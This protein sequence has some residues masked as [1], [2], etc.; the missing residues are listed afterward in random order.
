[1]LSAKALMKSAWS[2]TS[3]MIL[4]GNVASCRIG[5]ICCPNFIHVKY[6]CNPT[7]KYLQQSKMDEQI[8]AFK[9][10]NRHRNTSKHHISIS[11][12][13]T[14]VQQYLAQYITHK[15]QQTFSVTINLL[16][17]TLHIILKNIDVNKTSFNITKPLQTH[18]HV[19][20]NACIRWSNCCKH[21]C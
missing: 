8:Y 11:A 17:I 21:P 4:H 7:S 3:N 13:C 19:A 10:S 9:L 16:I 14:C 1:M 12:L 6:G 5:C 2:G 20:G 18:T 15:R